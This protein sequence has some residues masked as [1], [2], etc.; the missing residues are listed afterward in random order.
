MSSQSVSLGQLFQTAHDEGDLSTVSFNLLAAPDLGA[1]MMAG[2]G[3]PA[4][5]I[6]ASEVV[7]VGVLI[8]DSGS[9]GVN[10]DVTI[11][12]HNLILDAVKETKQRSG[13]LVTTSYLHGTQINAFVQVDQATKLDSTN[14]NP[15]GGTPLYDRAIVFLG[16]MIA[17]RQECLDNGQ[18]VRCVSLIVSDG[19]DNQSNHRAQ[20][21]AALVA[22]MNRTEEHIIQAMGI[23]DGFTNFRQIFRSMGIEDRWILT[24]KNT[25]GE[26]RKAFQLASRSSARASQS[27]GSFSQT[28]MG[29]FAAP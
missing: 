5:D 19:A 3:M 6:P 18:S 8:D 10:V 12:G 20:D 29:G 17:K 11:E 15:G 21:V 13:I 1:Q 26:I 27:A 16:Q 25:H 4:I 2:M 23:D 7:L 14:Y 28:A 24:P 22:D 9:M